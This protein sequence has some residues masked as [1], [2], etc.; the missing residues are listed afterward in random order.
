MGINLSILEWAYNFVIV[1]FGVSIFV[2]LM[3]IHSKMKD[4]KERSGNAYNSTC[5]RTIFFEPLLYP[6]C[7]IF[8]FFVRIKKY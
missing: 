7:Y 1:A 6:D 5:L 8:N 4:I 3:M 2:N